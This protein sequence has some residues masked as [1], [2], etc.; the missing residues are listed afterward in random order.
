MRKKWFGTI[1]VAVACLTAAVGMAEEIP[2]EVFLQQA[3]RPHAAQST[4]SKMEGQVQHRRRGASVISAPLY[5]GVWFTP[6]RTAAQLIIDGTQGYMIGQSFDAGT[7]GS[8]VIPM[9]EYA[10]PLLDDFGLRASDLTLAFIFWPLVKEV[11]KSSVKMQSCRVLV[12][13]SPEAADWVKVYISE[14][15]RFPLKAEWFTTLEAVDTGKPYRTLEV[16]A[17]RREGDFYAPSEL[18]IKGP[19]WATK[20][21]FEKFDMGICEP[22]KAPD[23]FRSLPENP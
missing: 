23:V 3:R 6:E 15:Y 14:E 13:K 18:S 17:F 19:G 16:P 9:G 1:A 7:E 22:G 12:L 5:L 20:V 11:D 8:S 10:K 2:A 4:Y 21:D